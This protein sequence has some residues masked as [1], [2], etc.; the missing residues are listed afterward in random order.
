MTSYAIIGASRAIGLAYVRLLVARPDTTVFAVVR[1]ARTSVHLNAAISGLKNAAAKQVL[2]LSGGKLD[3]F[4]HNA[5]RKYWNSAFKGYDVESMDEVDEDFIDAFRV[6]TLGVIHG[7]LA[8]LPLLHTSPAPLKVVVISTGAADHITM[9][10]FG[11]SDMVSYH[12]TKAAALMATTKGGGGVFV[13]SLTPG[14]VDVTET[15]GEHG[16]ASAKAAMKAAADKLHAS[17]APITQL[18]PEESVA[19]QLNIIDGLRPEDNG[20]LLAHTGGAWKESV[21]AVRKGSSQTRSYLLPTLR[22]CPSPRSSAHPLPPGSSAA[23]PPRV[24][25]QK[26]KSRTATPS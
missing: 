2:E 13:V 1:N 6:N 9:R 4:I 5:V 17:G 26:P 21:V 19:A 8:F 22:D 24:Q 16:D 15:F 20:M 18:S 11:M 7:I 3:C 10:T 25:N 23:P 12:T 14:P